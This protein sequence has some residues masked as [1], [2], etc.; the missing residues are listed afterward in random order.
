MI[1][2]NLLPQIWREPD[3][4]NLP[5]LAA[6]SV[7]VLIAC[8]GAFYVG[9]IYIID[10]PKTQAAIKREQ[11]KKAQLLL[12]VE[13]VKVK[14]K[15][16][17]DLKKRVNGL[18]NLEKS[19][20]LWSRFLYYFK[21][22]VPEQRC[23]IRSFHVSPDDTN[24]VV[25]DNVGK[26]YKLELVG[27]TNGS[28]DRECSQILTNFQANLKEKFGIMMKEAEKKDPAVTPVPVP[29]APVPEAS[30]E[31]AVG[32]EPLPEGFQTDIKLKFGE[33][34]VRS[35]KFIK[36]AALSGLSGKDKPD[37]YPILD[38]G[39]E[40]NLTMSFALPPPIKGAE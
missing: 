5:R 13:K 35:T 20:I 30:P 6:V 21:L 23:V 9:K 32:K 18:E 4:P 7:C 28:T 2:I 24:E 1:E 39:L 34:L 3:G 15:E 37:Q 22:S 17:D 36:L 14:D 40:F 8:V 12:D 11:D 38:R 16:L 25:M 31:D 26:R 10:I 19:R 29:G 27:F 33:P